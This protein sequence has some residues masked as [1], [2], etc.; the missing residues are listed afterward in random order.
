M[1]FY[2]I[3]LAVYLT[4]QTMLFVVWGLNQRAFFIGLQLLG[5]LVLVTAAVTTS[6]LGQFTGALGKGDNAQAL[7]SQ[8]S[9]WSRV[10]GWI[11][12]LGW[13]LFAASFLAYRKRRV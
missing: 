6:V 8:Y 2:L 12:W 7:V 4:V 3:P 13:P 11:Q 10:N 5:F 9:V 1:P